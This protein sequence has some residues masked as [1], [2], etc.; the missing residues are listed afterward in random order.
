MVPRGHLHTLEIERVLLARL[1]IVYVKRADDLLPLDHI[2]GVDRSLRGVWSF[3]ALGI[4]RTG[5]VDEDSWRAY[6]GDSCPH[7]VA[8]VETIFRFVRHGGVP[9]V[10]QESQVNIVKVLSQ[11][12]DPSPLH[13]SQWMLPA[14]SHDAY[15]RRL[16]GDAETLTLKALVAKR[17]RRS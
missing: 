15:G 12:C 4:C 16:A 8:P 3:C 1:Q 2:A 9:Y 7:E 13:S 11:T 6:Q 5:I 14:A 17:A 10:A